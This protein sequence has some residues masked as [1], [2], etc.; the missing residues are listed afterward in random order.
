M[1][2]LAGAVDAAFLERLVERRTGW[3]LS[4]WEQVDSRRRVEAVRSGHVNGARPLS[5]DQMREW[6]H[7]WGFHP[8]DFEQVWVTAG[9]VAK[10]D[11][12]FNAK[13]SD[14]KVITG[15]LVRWRLRREAIEEVPV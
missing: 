14:G 6:I 8:E 7:R 3:T 1:I 13:T 4:Q 10:W 12:H 5:D 15:G 9:E 11:P 2:S